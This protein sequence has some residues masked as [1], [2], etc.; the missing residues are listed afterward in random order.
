MTQ[1]LCAASQ[2]AFSVS[3][4][5]DTTRV[6]QIISRVEVVNAV[7]DVGDNVRGRGVVSTSAICLAES[8]LAAPRSLS[9]QL[10]LLRLLGRSSGVHACGSNVGVFIVAAERAIGIVRLLA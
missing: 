5:A 3:F 8:S 9:T 1:S 7:V 10:L 6:W 2:T 4:D